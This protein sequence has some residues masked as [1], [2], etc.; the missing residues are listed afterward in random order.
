LTILSKQTC[1][2]VLDTAL[3][4]TRAQVNVRLY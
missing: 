1:G 3:N 4:T 2:D